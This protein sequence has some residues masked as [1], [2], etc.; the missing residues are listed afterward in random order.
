VKA[1]KKSSDLM[2]LAEKLV[3]YA[4]HRGADEIEVSIADGQEFS[5]DVRMGNIESLVEAG[6]RYLG[7]RVIKDK[8]TATATSSDLNIDTLKQLL[9]NSIRRATLAN[10]DEYAGLPAQTR[11]PT[12]VSSLDIFDPK[13]PELDSRRKISLAKDTEKI[14]L[15]DKRITNSHGASFETKEIRSIM[16]NSSGFSHEYKET[17]CSLSVGIQAGE[18][19]SK[20][21]D[22][23]SSTERHFHALDP[24]EKVAKKAVERTI[25][26]LNPKKIKT[27]VVPV[28]FEPTMTSWLLGFLFSCVSG[29][30]V[31]QKLTF[32]SNKLGKKIGNE[33]VTVYDDGQMPGK[34]GTRPYDS[35]GILTKK[36]VVIAKGI[37]QN[38]LC[39]TYSGKKLK[40]PSTGNADG[41]GVGPNNFYLQPGSKPPEEIVKKTEKGLIL[42]RTIGHGL[43]PVTGDISR[44]AFGLWIERGEIVYPVAEITIAGNLGKILNQIEE[45]GNDLE[46]Q[47]AICGPTI[48]IQELTVAGE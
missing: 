36:N 11:L 17:V 8:K 47:S 34:L 41:A 28:I 22:Y 31:Y 42:L 29:M 14:A 13:I 44:G 33:T 12:D 39:N 38:F 45:V 21:E 46:F 6:F 27:Q 9:N 35:E 1:N 30:A 18:T 10:P 2:A 25:R 20:V 37:L 5:A 32:L 26:Q 43:N 19:D 40:L 7:L 15:A 23:W 24:P 4:R 3:T 16:A 48:K